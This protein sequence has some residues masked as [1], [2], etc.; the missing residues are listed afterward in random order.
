MNASTGIL[1]RIFA[2]LQSTRG[3]AL[4]QQRVVWYG[5]SSG[6]RTG[7][8]RSMGKIQG[9]DFDRLIPCHGDVIETGGK[10]IFEKVMAWHLEKKNV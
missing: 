9:W 6:D 8:A 5:T 1:T 3:K 4:A 2:A 10:G 7:F